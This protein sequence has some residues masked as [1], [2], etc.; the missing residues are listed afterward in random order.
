MI[1][2]VNVQTWRLRSLYGLPP[3]I[4]FTQ[5]LYPSSAPAIH[6]R[7]AVVRHA[8]CERTKRTEFKVSDGKVLCYYCKLTVRM[9]YRV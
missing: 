6:L 8:Q 7:V 5:C 9:L 2:R 1:G 3:T 4:P